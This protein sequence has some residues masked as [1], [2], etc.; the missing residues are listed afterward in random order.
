MEDLLRKLISLSGPSGFETSISEFIHRTIM[1]LVDEV[2]VD[3]L[4]NL[5]A[6]KKG[7]LSKRS[8]LLNAHMDEVGFMIRKIED[9]GFLRFEKL[10]GLDDQILPARLVRINTETG[11]QYGVIGTV[12]AHLTERVKDREEVKYQDLYID[13]GAST[14]QEVRQL[15][16]EVGSHGGFVGELDRI[17]YRRIVGKSLDD[18]VG[19]AILLAVLQR[20]QTVTLRGDLYIAFTVQEEVGLRGATV[21]AFDLPSAVSALTVDTTVATDTLEDI[22]DQSIQLGDGP[23]IEYKDAGI[24]TDP[25]MRTALIEVAREH[26]IPFQLGVTSAGRTDASAIQ[27]T[28]RGFR[29][30]VLAIPC[31]YTHSPVEVVD[32]HDVEHAQELIYQF[33]SIWL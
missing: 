11:F 7:T 9:D 27:R 5:L 13:V 6:V 2:R 24:I 4:G 10:G 31:R 22:M 21:A 17:G 16:I 8:L 14:K 30:A 29:A 12:P 26:S 1:P 23:V 25:I 19:C 32:L 28:K 3:P 15:G 33:I 20:L 18:R